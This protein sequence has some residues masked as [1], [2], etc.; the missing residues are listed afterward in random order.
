VTDANGT[1]LGTTKVLADGSFEVML[2][3]AQINQQVLAVQ[4][5]DPPGNVS[6]PVSVEAPDLTPPAAPVQLQLNADGSE[7]SGVGEPGSTARVYLG[8]TEIGTV[9]VGDDGRFVVA[10]S[11]SQNNG[12]Q[13][14]VTLEDAKGN[15][16]P[17]IPA[18]APDTTPPPAVNATINASGTQLNGT[19]E[20]G[21]RLTVLNDK[22]DLVGQGNIGAD[23][24]F[25]LNLSPA[26]LNGQVL[27]IVAQDATGNPSP[28]F[29]VTAPDLTPPAQPTGLSVSA[30]GTLLSG[31]GEVGSFITVRAPDNTVVGT[32]EVPAGGSFNVAL[33]PAQ[34]DGQVLQVVA[35]D[36]SGNAAPAVPVTAEDNSPPTPVSNLVIDATY[37]VISGRGEAGASVIVTQNGA[38]I[39]EGT[40]L[41][42]GTF[43]FALDTPAQP[44]QLV[45][46][47]QTDAAG[48]PSAPA[49]YTPPLIPLT[50]APLNVVLAGDGLTLT[51]TSSLGAVV[52]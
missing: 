18:T 40:V 39:G 31:T 13:L 5:A 14:Q 11:P 10:L 22:G 8:S 15:L 46:V 42:N 6:Q 50:E 37:S 35:T 7:L 43:Q 3:P 33:D 12:Q 17:S 38:K 41:A 45:S 34:N 51:G 9:Q 1:L 28:A 4:Q 23:G 48:N 49:D 44:G 21:A 29:A 32:I 2:T 16:S 47:V 27:S 19:G 24:S 36:A 20:A 25:V 52:T 30:D 26:Q